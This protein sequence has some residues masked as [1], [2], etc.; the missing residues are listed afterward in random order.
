MDPNLKEDGLW[1]EA[2]EQARGSRTGSTLP[3][4]P[5]AQP[6]VRQRS[7]PGCAHTAAQCHSCAPR[8]EH[9]LEEL[10]TEMGRL[11]L[12]S[13]E[14]RPGTA[15][16]TGWHKCPFL[17]SSDESPGAE[18]ETAKLACSQGLPRSASIPI[19]G[20]KGRCPRTETCPAPL[21]V[22][23]S[24]LPLCTLPLPGTGQELHSI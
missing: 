2:G 24:A 7:G 14:G 23:S 20:G 3:P 12:L 18:S 21:L 9:T 13:L 15:S 8:L 5:H 10:L 1:G 4:A 19:L 22:G 11:P 17:P 16:E 6:L